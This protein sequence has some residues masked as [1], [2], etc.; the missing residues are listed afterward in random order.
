MVLGARVP[1]HLQRRICVHLGHHVRPDPAHQAVSEKDCG[2]LCR[3]VLEHD[4][5]RGDLGH[6]LYAV[7][8]YDLPRARPRRQRVEFIEMHAEPGVRVAGLADLVAPCALSLQPRS[9]FCC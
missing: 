6:V 1:G 8:L 2:G 3:R 7:R 5:I 4:D 9:L